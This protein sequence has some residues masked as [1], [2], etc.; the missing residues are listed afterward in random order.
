MGN[1]VSCDVLSVLL[2]VQDLKRFS[3]LCAAVL[4]GGEQFADYRIEGND[5][6]DWWILPHAN[7]GQPCGTCKMMEPLGTAVRCTRTG[8]PAPTSA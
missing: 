2:L 3:S 8:F 6:L 7:V 5:G 4:A 1:S